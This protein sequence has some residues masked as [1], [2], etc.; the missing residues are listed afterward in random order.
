VNISRHILFMMVLL[1]W[2]YTTTCTG[3]GKAVA[4]EGRTVLAIRI[5][6]ITRQWVL[7]FEQRHCLRFHNAV[8]S[9]RTCIYF[10]KLWLWYAAFW[11]NS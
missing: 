9:G 11:A 3:V 8:N 2:H 10:G 1:V 7:V 5:S 4:G 6:W